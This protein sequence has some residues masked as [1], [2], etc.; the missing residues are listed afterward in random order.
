MIGFLHSSWAFLVLILFII[1]L[2]KYIFALLNKKIFDYNTDF[3]LA[4]FTL[5]VLAIQVVL[6]LVTWFFS[7]YFEGIKQGHFGEYMKQAHDRLLVIEHPVMMLI[8]LL[9]SRY[10]FN[11]MKKADTSQKKYI[12]VILTY[13]IS[14]LLILLRI[15]WSIW[16]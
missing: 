6:G 8:V 4:S 11:R 13:G 3:R 7:D 2:T 12:S 1:T 15:P 16:F 9:I 14:F 10:G 5:I